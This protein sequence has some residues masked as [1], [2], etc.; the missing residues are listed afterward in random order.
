MP[1]KRSAF[2]GRVLSQAELHEISKQVE[3]FDS[4]DVVDDEMRDLI[5]REW[6]DLVAKLPP[7]RRH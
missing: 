4:I 5:E 6:P 2:R 3:G 1:D 7:R